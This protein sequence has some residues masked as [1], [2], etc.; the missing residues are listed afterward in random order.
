MSGGG[1]GQ[2]WAGLGNNK[3]V[4]KN[5]MFSIRLCKNLMFSSTFC[6][7]ASVAL[8]PDLFAFDKQIYSKLKKMG[9]GSSGGQFVTI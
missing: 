2:K 3:N 7:L 9:Q 6:I 5:N 8:E 4:D 1:W